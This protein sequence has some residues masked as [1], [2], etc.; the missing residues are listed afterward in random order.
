MQTFRW[1]GRWTNTLKT[2]NFAHTLAMNFKS[3][4]TDALQTVD[5]LDAAG[6]VTGSED[7]RLE[8]TPYFTFDWQTQWTPRKEWAV[9][10]GVLN[11]LNSTPPLSLGTAGT[12]RGQQ[13]GYDNRYY[14]SRGRTL[15]ANVSYKF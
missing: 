6:K 8:I 13:F 10:F 12:N 9:T 14:D 7:L 4:Y 5:V 2:A 11:L 1:Q 3:G 15:Y